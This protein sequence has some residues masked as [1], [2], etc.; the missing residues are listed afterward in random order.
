[1]LKFSAWAENQAVFIGTLDNQFETSKCDN[2]THRRC[3]MFGCGD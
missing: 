1:M 2:Y 3:G